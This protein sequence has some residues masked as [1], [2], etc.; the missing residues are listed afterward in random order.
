MVLIMFGLFYRIAKTTSSWQLE[1]TH[2][3]RMSTEKLF[4]ETFA[5]SGGDDSQ[6]TVYNSDATRVYF[7]LLLVLELYY[8][9]VTTLKENRTTPCGASFVRVVPYNK[10][11]DSSL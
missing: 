6:Q 2:Y 8:S 9:T 1:A 5:D 10:K 11:G 3:L 7:R 4:K